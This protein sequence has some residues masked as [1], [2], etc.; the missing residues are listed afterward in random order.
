MKRLFVEELESR[1]LLNAG[2]FGHQAMPWTSPD[3]IG[4]PG[5]MHSDNSF[6]NFGGHDQF[7]REPD[8][9]PQRGVRRNHHDHHPF[10]RS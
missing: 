5:M 8:Q 3:R 10:S 9:S 2:G 4:T 7:D 1:N 6:A